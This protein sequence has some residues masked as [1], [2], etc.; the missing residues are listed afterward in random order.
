MNVASIRESTLISTL[1]SY[2]LYYKLKT[3]ELDIF[4][5]KNAYERTMT[6]SR[7]SSSTLT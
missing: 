4:A 5:R 2:V 6:S 3:H 7:A 1:T